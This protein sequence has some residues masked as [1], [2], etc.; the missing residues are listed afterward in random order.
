VE[1]ADEEWLRLVNTDR[2][3]QQ[4]DSISYETFEIVMDRLEKEWFGL[5]SSLI[6]ATRPFRHRCDIVHELWAISLLTKHN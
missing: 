5:V 2:K 6:P 3:S 4:L 1:Y